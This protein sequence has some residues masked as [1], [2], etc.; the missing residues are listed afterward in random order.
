MYFLHSGSLKSTAGLSILQQANDFD[1]N[2]V[3]SHGRCHAPTGGPNVRS[4][5]FWCPIL[6]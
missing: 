1:Y 3:T 6:Q 5:R 2:V 4:S